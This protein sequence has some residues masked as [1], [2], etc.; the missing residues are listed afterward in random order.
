MVGD[1]NE[2]DMCLPPAQKDWH[3]YRTGHGLCYLP[4]VEPGRSTGYSREDFLALAEGDEAESLAIFAAC[5][6]EGPEFFLDRQVRSLRLKELWRGRADYRRFL[7]RAL[8]RA[9]PL[10]PRED[11]V[12]WSEIEEDSYQASRLYVEKEHRHLGI[13]RALVHLLVA[14]GAGVEVRGLAQSFGS[15]PIGKRRVIQFYRRCGA[16]ISRHGVV[17]WSPHRSSI[18]STG[19]IVEAEKI[20]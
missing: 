15:D 2:R 14:A 12:L 6:W 10:A 11:W 8:P 20:H 4:A 3:A 7:G 16:S 1:V 9:V 18:E 17:T 5:L 13:G 19:A